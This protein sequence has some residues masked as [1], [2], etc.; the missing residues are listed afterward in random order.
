MRLLMLNVTFLGSVVGGIL[1]FLDIH[2]FFIAISGA[3]VNHD[4]NCGTALDPLVWS[5]GEASVGACFSGSCHVAWTT[6]YLCF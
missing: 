3:V 6:G 4:G 5:A 1:F 2:R